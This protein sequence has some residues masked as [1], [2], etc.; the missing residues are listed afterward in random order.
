MLVGRFVVAVSSTV[1]AGRVLDGGVVVFDEYAL[2]TYGE[3]NAVDEYFKGQK[4][5]LRNIT[6]AN[7]PS[8]YIVK[9]SF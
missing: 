9:E 6:W 5:R 1:L 2:R 3:S 7:T 8:A 4:I